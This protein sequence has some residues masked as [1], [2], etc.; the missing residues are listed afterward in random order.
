MSL[1]NSERVTRARHK[2]KQEIVDIMGGKCAICG[3]NKNIAAL[4]LHHINKEEKEFSIGSSGAYPKYDILI[5]E[6]KKCILLCANCHRE[7]HNPLEDEEEKV[8]VSSFNN[9]KAQYYKE[10]VVEFF[11]KE[12]K[13]CIDCGK[14]LSLNK[15]TRCPECA[16]KMQRVCERP[17]RE[18]LKTLI[19]LYP[20]TT[21]AVNYGVSDNAIRKWCDNYNLPRTKKEI[22]NY[23]DLEWQCL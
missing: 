15:S 13:F 20:F 6:L 1:T 23:S 4:E 8:L 19:R 10:L 11:K 12:E 18:E 2:R 5:P 21:I 9:E 16:K 22:N 7:V 14:T 3:Y 17:S